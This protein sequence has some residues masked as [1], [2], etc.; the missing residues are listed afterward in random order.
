MNFYSYKQLTLF[1]SAKWF[2]KRKRESEEMCLPDVFCTHTQKDGIEADEYE[3]S[4]NADVSNLLFC[5]ADG[6]TESSFSKEWADMLTGEFADVLNHSKPDLKIVL[7]RVRERAKKQWRNWVKNK[8]IPWY[9]EEKVKH[10]AD[11]AFIG[12]KILPEMKE[13]KAISVG[14][15][16]LFI[17]KDNKVVEKFPIEDASGFDSTP[18]LIGS[19]FYLK[20]GDIREKSGC[21]TGGEA[22]YLFSDAIAQWF[23]KNESSQPWDTLSRHIVTKET[24]QTFVDDLRKNKEMRNDDVTVM[25]LT[26]PREQKT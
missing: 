7:S 9:A 13:W 4:S 16:C 20:R 1:C 21:L 26:I 24:F 12:L 5:V 10:G 18:S 22:I 14:D 2:R 8:T 6:A 19:E 15:C 3:D 25:I 17:V 11:A 23:L